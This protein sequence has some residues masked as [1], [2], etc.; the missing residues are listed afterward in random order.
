MQPFRELRRSRSCRSPRTRG[1][2]CAP[3]RAGF[4]L[5][6]LLVVILIVGTLFGIGV[7]TLAS[8]DL[9]RRAARGSVLNVIRSARTSA[10]ARGA[11]S[12]VRFDTEN[13]RVV[14]EGV[15]V[16]G[17]WHFERDAT[18]AALF[19]GENQGGKLIDD[20]YIGRAISF[21]GAKPGSA[22]TV[23]VHQ[24]PGFDLSRGFTIECAL[25]W[26]GATSGRALNVGNIVQL[27]VT[28]AGTVRGSFVPVAEDKTRREI[29]GGKTSIETE[30]GALE[31]RKWV[32]VRLDY[33]RRLF[34]LYL[35]D[36]EVARAAETAKVW[37]LEG[38]LR[39]G[40]PKAGFPGALDRLVISAVTSS[41]EYALP[42][43]LVFGD[44]TPEELV[45][46][47]GGYLDREV[48]ARAVAFHLVDQD[49]GRQPVR[50]GLYGTVE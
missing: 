17:T 23:A 41:S 47:P 27:E 28:N 21:A 46:A 33:D 16:L 42:E 5:M 50:V 22:M 45:F 35:D 11:H 15:A 12:R 10:V 36:V 43:T 13:E 20:G 7:G 2:A 24:D 30:P 40:D 14:A 37:K 26:E 29:A 38:P 44:D 18:G 32:R 1:A 49:G 39:I 6:E 31:P 25:R 19:D 8:L 34:R 4:T 3:R 48:H 9:G